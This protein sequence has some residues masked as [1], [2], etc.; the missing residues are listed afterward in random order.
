MSEI[1]YT[2][3][4]IV[5]LVCAILLLRAYGLNRYKLLYWGGICFVGLTITNCLVIVDKL[6]LPHID[7][8]PLRLVVSLIAIA[9]LLYGL[10]WDTQ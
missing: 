3:C 2:L 1:V 10:I 4:T 5:S 6:I 8:F 7:L 9:L